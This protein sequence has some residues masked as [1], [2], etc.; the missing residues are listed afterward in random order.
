[1][2]RISFSHPPLSCTLALSSCSRF[3]DGQVR[4]A[5]QYHLIQ[6]RIQQAEGKHDEAIKTLNTAMKLPGIRKGTGSL[7]MQIFDIVVSLCQHHFLISDATPNFTWFTT[8]YLQRLPRRRKVADQSH[9]PIAWPCMWTWRRRTTAQA[10]RYSL[11]P[12]FA[13]TLQQEAAKVMQ[14]ASSEFAGTSEEVR[15]AQP[16]LGLDV[17]VRVR[18]LDTDALGLH[19][20]GVFFC[21]AFSRKFIVYTS[22]CSLP[23]RTLLCSVAMLT[24]R[25]A[26]CAPSRRPS[27]TS[28]VPCALAV[29]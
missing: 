22:E 13:L 4:E 18:V 9:P 19:M 15:Y 14:D 28:S 5:P 23:T 25:S 27:S 1:M 21:Q 17:R 10:R 8:A 24:V 20:L 6:A 16:Y 26:H 3:A 11:F 7:C 12:I 2:V 29:G